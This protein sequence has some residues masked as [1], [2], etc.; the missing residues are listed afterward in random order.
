MSEKK[1]THRSTHWFVRN[2]DDFLTLNYETWLI[3]EFQSELPPRSSEEAYNRW[4]R[5]IIEAKNHVKTVS[6]LHNLEKAET[7]TRLLGKKRDRLFK[8]ISKKR[9][10]KYLHAKVQW[11]KDFKRNIEEM[12]KA[13]KQASWMSKDEQHKVKQVVDAFIK[14]KL[15]RLHFTSPSVIGVLDT[16]N[17]H[18]PTFSLL[19]S[20]DRT[21]FKK[22]MIED[23]VFSIVDKLVQFFVKTY[24]NI[25][26]EFCHDVP[27]VVPEDLQGHVS[28]QDEPYAFALTSV[29]F[30]RHF[31]RN[32]KHPGHDMDKRNPPENHITVTQTGH[33]IDELFFGLDAPY[34]LTWGDETSEASAERIHKENNRNGRIPDFR[35]RVVIPKRKVEIMVGESCRNGAD[36]NKVT[37]DREKMIR[38]MKDV[39]ERLE[40][41]L[42]NYKTIDINR[43]IREQYSDIDLFAI[44]SIG[45]TKLALFTFDLVGGIFYRLR[46]FAVVSI[47]FSPSQAEDVENFI[48]TLLKFR[49]AV[50]RSATKIIKINET[51]RKRRKELYSI[52]SNTSEYRQML[53]NY[54]TPLSPPHD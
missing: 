18:D 25:N 40:R 3:R 42:V 28:K 31:W 46:K 2:A 4:S 27:F 26:W 7:D 44:Q 47:P 54:V 37:G 29:Q 19:S 14:T 6:E 11:K 13:M 50:N 49:F 41:E 51:V 34:I 15:E 12:Q 33:L 30:S 10:N 20:K 52:I 43:E 8:S 48:F 53:P 23:T 21:Y 45:Y 32:E 22:V 17:S 1:Y 35:L 9:Q 16:T 5:G 38:M 36:E 24:K 39:K